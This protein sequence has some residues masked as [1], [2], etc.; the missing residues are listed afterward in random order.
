MRSLRSPPASAS[1]TSRPCG[2]RRRRRPTSAIGSTP[3]RPLRTFT[4]PSSACPWTP[5]NGEPPKRAPPIGEP[6][7]NGGNG[8]DRDEAPAFS[9]EAL[10]LRFA[11]RHELALRYVAEWGQWLS[12]TGTHWLADKTLYAFD[13]ARRIAR[14]TA[15]T[16]TNRKIASATTS[17]KTVAAVERL[18]KADRRHAARSDQWDGSPAIFNTPTEGGFS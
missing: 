16:I 18:A 8:V 9:E 2:P 7:R 17:A 15:R 14:E 12:W 3:A 4:A 6:R 5:G 13:L 10:A 11:E 1:L